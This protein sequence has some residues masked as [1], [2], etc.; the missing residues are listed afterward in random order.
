MDLRQQGPPVQQQTGRGEGEAEE[1]AAGGTCRCPGSS[2]SHWKQCAARK[3]NLSNKS[4]YGVVPA[5]VPA[6]RLCQGVICVIPL[7]SQAFVCVLAFLLIT[8][9]R[10]DKKHDVAL[11]ITAVHKVFALTISGGCPHRPAPSSSGCDAHR[12]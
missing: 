6:I 2:S 9:E 11:Q 4:T 8:D 10:V 3:E 1:Q 7:Y 12:L 5:V